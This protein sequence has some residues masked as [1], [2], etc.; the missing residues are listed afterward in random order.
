MDTPDGLGH[1]VASAVDST[2]PQNVLVGTGRFS[3]VG[4][5]G[6]WPL[7]FWQFSAESNVLFQNVWP[8]IGVLSPWGAKLSNV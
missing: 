1:S 4:A 8:S 2:P 6:N 5:S 7:C 3:S